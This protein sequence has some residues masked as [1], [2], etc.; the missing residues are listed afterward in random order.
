MVRVGKSE[1]T[2][3]V[4]AFA[5][6]LLAHS[7]IYTNIIPNFDGISR[8][9][10]EQQ[11]T[12]SGRWFLHYASCLYGYVQSP[13][14][15]G[16][17]T[18]AFLA[19]AA[20]LVVN[21]LDIDNVLMAG[22]WG[23]LSVLSPAIAYTNSYTF[24]V[25]AYGFAVLLAVQAVWLVEKKGWYGLLGG[26]I[27]LAL[28]MGIYQVYVTT[29]ITLSLYLV[30]IKTVRSEGGSGA[31]FVSGLKYVLFLATGTG[32]YWLVLKIFLKV[33]DLRLLSYL[34]MNQLEQGYPIKQIGQI[35]KDTYQE[36]VKYFFYH[37]KG[38]YDGVM[39]RTTAVILLIACFVIALVK[40][41][42]QIIKGNQPQKTM[43]IIILFCAILLLPLGANFGKIMSPYSATSPSMKYT[44]VY[45]CLL[46]V[47]L[48][49]KGRS[50]NP[51]DGIL[52]KCYLR[53]FA[54]AAILLSFQF[55][56]QDNTLYTMLDQAH[57]ATLSFVTNVVGRIESCPGYSMG[58]PVVIVG[59]YPADRYNTT[60]EAYD[61][62][63]NETFQASSVIP[64]NKHIYYYM[65]DWINV[66]IEE[67][68]REV[69]EE[70]AGSDYFQQ[71]PRY[72]DDGS[73]IIRDGRVIVKMQ[74][75]YTPKAQYE[76]DYEN[77]R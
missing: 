40:Q 21:L 70:V 27:L 17:L 4:A 77:R 31:A 1:K 16:V 13:M 3:F 6:G 19:L 46:P 60:I 48:R 7:Y 63:G 52:R 24:T 44:Y 10:D 53:G 66:P 61:W 18:M 36:V 56:Q 37:S 30:L 34:G 54:I 73:V 35:L 14:I 50:P 12:V 23:I 15:I 71:M 11:M 42:T 47:T 32:L 57:R 20:A 68:A 33:K 22:L 28:S 74:D 45:L 41:I 49:G 55:W 76:I 9:F 58:M 67:P 62:V 59:G 2:A 51:V 8:V 25:A 38:S 65:N 64:L 72:P 39:I 29:A 69:F 26:C 5:G 75:T 43:R